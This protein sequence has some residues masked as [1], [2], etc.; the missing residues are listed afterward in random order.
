MSTQQRGQA[1]QTPSAEAPSRRQTSASPQWVL[2][3]PNLLMPEQPAIRPEPEPYCVLTDCLRL[4][5]RRNRVTGDEGP[6]DFLLGKAY[7]QYAGERY[8]KLGITIIR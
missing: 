8:H 7:V 3:H 6:D 2:K 5:I 1:S 4:Q